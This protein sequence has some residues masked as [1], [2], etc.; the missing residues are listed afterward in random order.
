MNWSCHNFAENYVL[1]GNFVKPVHEYRDLSNQMCW[2]AALMTILEFY[3]M[4]LII[5]V[6]KLYVWIMCR[7]LM[8][9]GKQFPPASHKVLRPEMSKH[10]REQFWA[11]S[12]SVTSLS[13]CS[14]AALLGRNS[15]VQEPRAAFLSLG[16]IYLILKISILQKET[17][18]FFLHFSLLFP[19][20]F[21][22]HGTD[23][24]FP[25]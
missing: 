2:L 3:N 17:L 16:D 7:L 15:L 18:F 23:G 9:I 5:K 1:F 12:L 6:I 10:N 25:G 14:S 11:K 22:F 13:V 4:A 24:I 8:G 20:F 21:S 19:L